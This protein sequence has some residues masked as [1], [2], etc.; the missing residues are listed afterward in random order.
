MILSKLKI[1]RSHKFQSIRDLEAALVPEP[2]T[3]CPVI[4]P[5]AGMKLVD[6]LVALCPTR[7]I[8]AHT[9]A[10]FEGGELA[11]DLGRC[12]FCRECARVAPAHIRFSN[13]HRMA[14]TRRQ[15]LLITAASEGSV[16]FHQSSVDAR[17]RSLFRQALKLREVSAGGDNAGEMELNAS[18]NVNFDL[19]RLGIE[20]VASPRHADGLVLTGPISRNMAAPLQVCWDAIPEPKILIAVGADAISGGLFADSPAVERS[21]LERHTPQLYVPGHPAHPLT[22][23]DGVMRLTGQAYTR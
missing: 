11:I 4:V 2:Y 5:G 7:A 6:R 16:P 21:F 18:Q 8:V 23:I 13:N 12:I 20:F 19:G 3:G 1:W 14:A 15:D 22:F 10:I 17:I 9:E